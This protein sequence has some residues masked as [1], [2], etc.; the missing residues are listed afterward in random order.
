MLNHLHI[1]ADEI[2][3]IADPDTNGLLWVHPDAFGQ[4]GVPYVIKVSDP[5]TG[6]SAAP[7]EGIEPPHTV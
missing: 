3:P 7:P 4:A 1:R 6:I 2:T 5:F